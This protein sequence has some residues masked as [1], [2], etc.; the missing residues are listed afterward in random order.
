M[1]LER[2]EYPALLVSVPDEHPASPRMNLHFA[3][4]YITANTS[5]V[6]VERPRQT[7]WAGQFKHSRLAGGLSPHTTWS[8][9]PVQSN[10]RNA[11]E[12]A[13]GLQKLA[14]RQQQDGAA[15]LG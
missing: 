5:R 4:G 8:E 3:P 11:V 9:S 14:R 6:P 2:Q 15:A 12:Y 7:H 1:A 13:A 10:T